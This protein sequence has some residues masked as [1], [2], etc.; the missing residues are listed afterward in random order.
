MKDLWSF[1]PA[2]ENFTFTIPDYMREGLI[3]YRQQGVPPGGF[4][5]KVLENDLV[6]AAGKADIRNM[7]NLPA[8]ANFLYNCMPRAAWG[9]PDRVKAWIQRG[10]LVGRRPSEACPSDEEG[11]PNP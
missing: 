10:G 1:S 7:T 6:E 4:L 2:G 3:A 9:S 11:D 8:Y 5:T